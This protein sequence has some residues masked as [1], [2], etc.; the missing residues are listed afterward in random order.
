MKKFMSMV[1]ALALSAS[2]TVYADAAGDNASAAETEIITV[3]SFDI[4]RDGG[5]EAVSGDTSIE[6]N[7]DAKA[8][9][10]KAAECLEGASYEPVAVIGRQVVA[11]MNYCL[12]CKVTA[13]VPDAKPQYQLVYI[14]E[15]LNGGASITGI[16]TIIGEALPGGFEA[17]T[18]DTD[19][20][21]NKKAAAA[22]GKTM[23]NIDGVDYEPIAYLGSQVVAGTNYMILCRSLVISPNSEPKFVL[24]TIYEDLSGNTEMNGVET[25]GFGEKDEPSSGSGGSGS[26]G[27]DMPNPWSDFNSVKKAA[28]AA[29]LT[30]S[31]PARL[32]GKKIC[33]VR[34]KEGLVEVGYG[35]KS[36]KITFRKGAGTSDISG[37]WNEYPK[38][39]DVKINGRTVT[40]RGQKSKV[41][42]IIWCDGT[43]SYSFYVKEGVSAKT[44]K[45]L[46]AALIAENN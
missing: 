41:Y 11:G 34:A 27:T 18:G 29:G 42:S 28:K 36:E 14:Y 45:K 7:P 25:I 31:A 20:S 8:A 10:D 17:N 1:I 19:L 26:T 21:K 9:F 44:A 4:H 38:T 46:A 33:F 22:F 32:G 24:V 5:W 2:M 40:M 12:L 35:S 6:G 39:A 13:V 3:G 16:K 37:D 43:D 30:F 23:K 15:D